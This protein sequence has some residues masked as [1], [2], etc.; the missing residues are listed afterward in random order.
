MTSLLISAQV[1][2][3]LV[4]FTGFGLKLSNIIVEIGQNNVLLCLLLSMFICVL[5]GMGLPTTAAYILASS[6]LVPPLSQIGIPIQVGH[7]FVFYFAVLSTITPPVCAAV[8][9][10]SGIAKSNWLKTG[11]VACLMALPIFI[12]PFAFVYCNGLLLIPGEPLPYVVYAFITAL[13]GVVSIAIGVA[14]YNKKNLSLLERVVCVLCGVVMVAPSVIPATI[15]V[16]I[17]LAI[18]IRTHRVSA[19]SI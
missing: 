16:I 5:L 8:F 19:V 6:V 7:F 15:A 14:G 10:S 4:Q 2:I 18:F 17:F 12:I 11:L 3:T 9:I 13:L 1:V